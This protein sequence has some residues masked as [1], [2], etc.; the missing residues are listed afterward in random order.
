[1]KFHLLFASAFSL[2]S[3]TAAYAQDQ[4]FTVPDGASEEL[5][6]ALKPKP[7]LGDR[8]ISDQPE[9]IQA[10]MRE[11]LIETT[12][13]PLPPVPA[14][15]KK[16]LFDQLMAVS[17]MG[18]RDL[19]NFMTSKKKAADGVTFDEVIESMLIK[20]NEV[21]F[22]NVGHNKFWKDASAVTGYP[23]LRVEILQFCDAVVGRRMLD[24][25]PEFS[26]FIPCR[27]TVMEDANGDIWLMT[28]DW[29]VSWLANAWHPDSELSDQLKEDALRI[30]DAMEAIMHAG[31][32]A[33]W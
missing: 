8:L 7:E 6:E 30:R 9:D 2:F 3:I 4:G 18:M 31:A 17:G 13:R 32:N 16:Q 1:M 19:F 21:N 26:I 33:L 27:I 11:Q 10:V 23:A 24:F 5:A 22:K 20:A 25:S 14:A 15:T 28:L 29:D 12:N